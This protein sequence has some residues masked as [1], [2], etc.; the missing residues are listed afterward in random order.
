MNNSELLSE[1]LE[2]AEAATPPRKKE[3]YGLPLSVVLI[4][5]FLFVLLLAAC[6]VNAATIRRL[7]ER[8]DALEEQMLRAESALAEAQAQLERARTD[9]EANT[10]Q[11]V[12]AAPV[13]YDGILR[14]VAHRGFSTEA[15]EN[16]LPAFRLAKE[17][18][19][20][21][22]ETDVQFTAD[23]YAVCLHDQY[24]DRVS[25]GSG[26]INSMTLEEVRQ[27]DFG[28]W[29][30]EAYAGT[31]IPTLEEFLELCRNLGL[32]PYIEMKAETVTGEVRARQLAQIVEACGMKGKVTWISFSHYL[33]SVMRDCDP[34]APLGYLVEYVD[35]N[36]V[37]MANTL[38]NGRNRV[39]LDAG[40]YTDQ[41]CQICMDNDMPLELW[42]LDKEDQIL[43][44]NPFITG[45]TS[46]CLI[47][48]KVRYEAYTGQN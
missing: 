37:A 7:Q 22:V 31:K 28:A 2:A 30:G 17:R 20:S 23:G 41:G 24:I 43:S 18:G 6:I 10:A 36:A 48:G 16:T 3:L 26:A 38:R 32:H 42:V 5:F 44:L 8:G 4:I 9:A 34:E 25:S 47:A 27:Y 21:Y 40:S 45:V 12:T 13:D 35:E 11:A 29:K 46:N 19:F 33:L 1:V 39:F 14:A 15:P